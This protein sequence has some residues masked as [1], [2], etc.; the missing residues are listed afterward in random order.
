MSCPPRRRALTAPLATTKMRYPQARVSP[1]LLGAFLTCHGK[2]VAYVVTR[3]RL[4]RTPP[5]IYVRSVHE[6]TLRQTLA[7]F[8][9]PNVRPAST[10]ILICSAVKSAPRLGIKP[11]AAVGRVNIVLPD[12]PTIFLAA[13]GAEAA[14]Q[15]AIPLSKS[16][17][18]AKSG[19]SL[20]FFLLVV[21]GS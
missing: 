15:G 12:M 7:G 11:I 19:K 17:A 10:T 2:Q 4:Q 6:V 20:F 21:F 14:I 3:I 18:C 9:V 13:R 1:A 8:F 5:W 16:N